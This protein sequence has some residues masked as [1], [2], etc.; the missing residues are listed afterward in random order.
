MP[1][2][3]DLAAFVRSR[4]H[5]GRDGLIRELVIEGDRQ[6]KIARSSRSKAEHTRRGEGKERLQD[7]HGSARR[8]VEPIGRAL[9]FLRYR[10]M[11]SGA[12]EED[13][14]LYKE[15]AEKFRRSSGE[16][17]QDQ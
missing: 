6:E 16:G 8:N 9:S 12:T 10:T 7:R 14:A 13:L 1:R 17:E 3:F 2:E 4:T 11:P 15:L 5:L